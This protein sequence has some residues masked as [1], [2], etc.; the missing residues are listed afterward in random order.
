ML[1]WDY[2]RERPKEG[3]IQVVAEWSGVGEGDGGESM[4][5]AS[6][7]VWLDSCR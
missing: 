1:E 7:A 6:H 4:E 3:H 2:E 5:G